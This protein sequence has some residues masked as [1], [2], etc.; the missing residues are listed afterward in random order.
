MFISAGKLLM[1]LVR[2]HNAF[3]V[4]FIRIWVMRGNTCPET[5]NFQHN[6]SAVIFKKFFVV[7]VGNLFPYIMKNSDGYMPLNAA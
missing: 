6:F 1:E 2:P 4:V 5:G 3:D 7:C